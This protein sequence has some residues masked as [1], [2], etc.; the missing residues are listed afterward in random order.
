LRISLDQVRV[1]P[2]RWEESLEIPADSLGAPEL[3]ELSPLRVRGK[4]TF[5]DP[6]FHLHAEVTYT[7]SLRCD[8]CLEPFDAEVEVTVD[9]MLEQAGPADHEEAR[10]P[11]GKP[12]E[13]GSRRPRFEGAERAAG[14]E[15]DADEDQTQLEEDELGIVRVAGNEI[16]TEPL[17]AEQVL[18]NLPMKPLCRPACAGLCPTCG[19][20]RN[21][22]HCGCKL[23]AD[24]RLAGLE[25]WFDKGS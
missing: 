10:T 25:A 15:A 11:A 18:L 4:V 21:L 7:Q 17:L 2:V 3:L 19:A 5:V 6:S 9:L 16:S 12:A 24:A 22:E 14:G 20:D 13:P 8:R 23:P 1:E